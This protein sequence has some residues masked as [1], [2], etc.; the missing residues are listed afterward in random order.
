VRMSALPP[1]LKLLKQ[2][3]S[4]VMEGFFGD[5]T[6]IVIRPSMDH[7]VQFFNELSLGGMGVLFDEEL[8]FLDVTLDRL[9][10][11]SDDGFEAKRI[12][13]SICASVHLSHREL[14]HSPA[15]KVKPYLFL[16]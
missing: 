11:W 6:P 4:A 14:S 12:S 15:K 1:S 8:Q 13:P 5:H 7:L 9:F 16:V 2:K 10:T 3:V